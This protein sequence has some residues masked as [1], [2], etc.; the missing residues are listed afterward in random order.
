MK[1]FLLAI[2]VVAVALTANS[3]E[4][5]FNIGF[6]GGVTKG[7]GDFKDYVSGGVNGYLFG[8]YNIDEKLSAGLEL[9]NNVLVS[10]A[11]DGE[12][13]SATTV[14]SYLLKG[15]YYFTDTK[16]RPYGAVMTG[17]YINKFYFSGMDEVYEKNKFGFGAELGLKIKWFQLG[18]KYHN[19]GKIEDAKLSYMQYHLGFNFSF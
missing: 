10:I 18:V 13:L 1:K 8:L 5:K 6:G 2:L 4:K 11:G 7:M 12:T 9:N 16:V 15:V 17:M 14:N 19:M 3:Q